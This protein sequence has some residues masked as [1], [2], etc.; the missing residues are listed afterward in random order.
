MVKFFV[1]KAALHGHL[2][3]I[4]G[5]TSR[6]VIQTEDEQL[7]ISQS[8]LFM[9]VVAHLGR[10]TGEVLS[11]LSERYYW[12]EMYMYMCVCMSNFIYS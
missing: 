8:R 6:L 4:G 9:H 5:N 1:V 7:I 3:Y 12:P 10:G 2:H 11:Q